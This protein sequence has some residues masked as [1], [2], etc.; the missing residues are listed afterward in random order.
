MTYSFYLF[1]YFFE[2]VLG[3]EH[4][5][6]VKKKSSATFISEESPKVLLCEDDVDRRAK[7]D[8]SS[9]RTSGFDS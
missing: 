3:R 6:K 7:C 1:I 8:I 9:S 5:G 2:T 4:S